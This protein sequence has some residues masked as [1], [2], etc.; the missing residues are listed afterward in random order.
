VAVAAREDLVA[1]GGSN[2]ASSLIVLTPKPKTKK[3]HR[4]LLPSTN[5]TNKNKSTKKQ[6]KWMRGCDEKDVV[7]RNRIFQSPSVW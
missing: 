3:P 7:T 5:L 6:R 2:L 1:T 4:Q